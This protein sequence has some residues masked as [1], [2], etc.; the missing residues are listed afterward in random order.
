MHI[1]IKS[2]TSFW[3]STVTVTLQRLW[4]VHL[5]VVL[6][7]FTGNLL[8]STGNHQGVLGKVLYLLYVQWLISG[9]PLLQAWLL[10]SLKEVSPMAVTLSVLWTCSYRVGRLDWGVKRSHVLTTHT[11]QPNYKVLL[12]GCFDPPPFFHG[13]FPLTPPV[14]N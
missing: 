8:S 9:N 4:F 7:H 12:H 3:L 11:R 1:V 14:Q 6:L 5:W 2:A 13:P 10:T